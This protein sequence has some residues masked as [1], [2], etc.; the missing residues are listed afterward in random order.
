[1]QPAA[2]AA[3]GTSSTTVAYYYYYYTYPR[4]Y[5]DKVITLSAPP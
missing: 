4:I 3:A 2:A 1:V 5:R